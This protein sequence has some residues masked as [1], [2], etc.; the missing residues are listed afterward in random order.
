MLLLEIV[1]LVEEALPEL[2]KVAEGLFGWKKKSGTEKKAFVAG[3]LKDVVG[4]IDANSRGGQKNTWDALQPIVDAGIDETASLLFPHAA[5]PNAN[6]I[7][8]G[9]QR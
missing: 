8:G 7:G 4:Q 5:G 1:G 9:V 2:V 6:A 3:T